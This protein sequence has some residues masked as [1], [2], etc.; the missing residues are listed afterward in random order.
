MDV[1]GE[2]E[3]GSCGRP[4]ALQEPGRVLQTQTQTTGPACVRLA[5]RGKWTCA[6]RSVLEPGF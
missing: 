1:W 4:A 3:G 5:L 2:H 6:R